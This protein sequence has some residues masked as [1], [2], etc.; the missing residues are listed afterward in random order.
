M[1]G[2]ATVTATRRRAWS[3]WLGLVFRLVV[4]GVMLVAGGLKVGDPEQAGA[5]VQAYRLLPPDLARVVGYA[6][7]TLEV[8]LGLLLVVGLFTR[9]AAAVSGALLVAFVVGIVSVWVRGYSIDCGCF[10]GGGDVSPEGLDRRY[11]TEIV[12]DVALIG[13]SAFLVLVR[14]TA[15]SVDGWLSPHL[16]HRHDAV[17]ADA[18]DEKEVV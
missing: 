17:V 6:L 2:A 14:R 1:S 7:P 15:L 4:G 18:E 9:V 3:A 5:A 8:V 12:R 11:A 13:M 10:G 16:H